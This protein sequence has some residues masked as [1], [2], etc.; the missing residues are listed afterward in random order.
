[1]EGGREGGR[2]G[3]CVGKDAH[4]WQGDQFCSPTMGGKTPCDVAVR[5]AIAV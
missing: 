1:M 2:E 5:Q 3:D 4:R